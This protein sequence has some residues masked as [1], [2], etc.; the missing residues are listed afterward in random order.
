MMKI[1]R[2]FMK[3]MVVLCCCAALTASVGVVTADALVRMAVIPDYMEDDSPA[4]NKGDGTLYRNVVAYMN[5]HL[6]NSNAVEVVNVFSSGSTNRYQAAKKG[7][8][9]SRKDVCAMF[10]ADAVIPVKITVK[11]DEDKQGL[12]TAELNILMWGYDSAG[13]DL[14]LGYEKTFKSRKIG[15][16]K[17][18]DDAALISGDRFGEIIKAWAWK[19]Y[20]PK[21]PRDPYE[22]YV[23]VVLSGA[24]KEETKEIFGK[25]L[26]S[27]SGV[28]QCDYY[29]N[30]VSPEYE[31]ALNHHFRIKLEN[32]EPLVFQA[33]V[34][35]MIDKI[36][37]ADGAITLKD[38]AYQYSPSDINELKGI[39]SGLAKRA[40][41]RFIMDR[42]LKMEREISGKYGS[43]EAS[44]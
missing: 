34:L 16:S 14:G 35:K 6:K 5:H 17:A 3:I 24:V 18:V 13:R 11:T 39:R 42:G 1:K 20:N 33:N 27:A 25:L 40:E 36:I 15:C 21:E 19:T 8:E 2:Q 30:D 23:N 44:K 28:F 4:P 29:G 32:M 43:N 26:S 7:A 37:A 10:H 31:E 22:G 38:V 41:I 9:L 12:C